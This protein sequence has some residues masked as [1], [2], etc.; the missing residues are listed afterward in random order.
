MEPKMAI[1]N[2]IQHP[3]TE[4]QIS[5][6]EMLGEQETIIHL[7]NSNPELFNHIANSP[8]DE[9]LLTLL[10]DKLVQVVIN[11]GFSSVILPL[12]S[13]AFMFELGKI[14]GKRGLNHKNFFAHTERRSTEEVQDDGSVKK[15]SLFEHVKWLRL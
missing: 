13:P 8:A 2:T 15:V 10:A 3:L 7:R 11:E 6:L 12:G 4:V 5:Q 14:I 1:L 9:Y